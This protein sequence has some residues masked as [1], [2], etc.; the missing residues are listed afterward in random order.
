LSKIRVLY[1][2]TLA[3][4]PA[5]TGSYVRG[6]LAALQRRSD[7]ELTTAT[8]HSSS[9]H[10][11]DTGRKPASSRLANSLRHLAYYLNRLPREARAARSDLIFCPSSLVPLRGA[12][13]FA[14]TVY[15][16]TA[17]R[18]PQTQD[19]FSRRYGALMLRRGLRHSTA[20]C[21]ISRAVAEEIAAE[22]DRAG[23]P[24]HVTYPGPNPELLSAIPQAMAIDGPHFLLMVGTLEPRK[25]QVTALRAF[26]DYRN[27]HPDTEL[28]L[29][30]AGS[31]GWRYHDILQTIDAL[32]LEGHVRR[33][34]S[35]SAGQLKWLYQHAR[36]LLF[37]SLYEGFGLPVLEAFAL[38]CPVVAADIPPVREIAGAGTAT[39]LDPMAVPS[40]TQAI[41]RIA[42]E[43]PEAAVVEAAFARA[44]AFTWD[45]TA[46]AVVDALREA[47]PRAVA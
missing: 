28:A 3:G 25:N 12:T 7:L 32:G 38:R 39:L 22:P 13:P 40:W 34:G 45:K 8:M 30:L 43:P 46:T 33:I 1:D 36:A 24:I 41:E 31:P 29:V 20:I 18:Y 11:L 23:Q 6:L 42:S 15:D 9:V 35:V 14:M 47:A 5:G 21:T 37:P 10:T 17:R 19:R 4:N 2:A 26:A 44:G 16:L 27:R